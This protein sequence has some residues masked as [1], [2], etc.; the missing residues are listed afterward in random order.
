MKIS[1]RTL[2]L[3]FLIMGILILAPYLAG[4]TGYVV[5]INTTTRVLG[6]IGLI[7]VVAAAVLE[8]LQEKKLKKKK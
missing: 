2:S 7:F 1:K 6:V 3:F 4:I 8:N 5:G